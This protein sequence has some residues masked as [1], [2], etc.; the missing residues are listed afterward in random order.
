MADNCA[1]AL[2]VEEC[3]YPFRHNEL[4]HSFY[5]EIPRLRHHQ[6]SQSDSE[7]RTIVEEKDLN[8][9]K[10]DFERISNSY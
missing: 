4:K 2:Y 3:T 6:C 5:L 1:T 7:N 10:G 9:I 8:T